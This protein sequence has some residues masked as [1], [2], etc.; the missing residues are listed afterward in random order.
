VFP[1]LGIYRPF[2]HQHFH[3]I[4]NFNPIQSNE[5]QNSNNGMMGGTK[6]LCETTIRSKSS[7]VMSV[8]DEDVTIELP[9]WTRRGSKRSG[10][11]DKEGSERFSSGQGSETIREVTSQT[12]GMSK[13]KI[14]TFQ[15]DEIVQFLLFT[16]SGKSSAGVV[17]RLVD[18]RFEVVGG[19]SGSG[20]SMNR[21]RRSIHRKL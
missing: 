19:W 10:G 11:D 20:R 3:N 15:A 18:L 4:K 12:L 14:I 7:S 8:N 21:I 1:P 13:I 6:K 9:D 5:N 17:G 16:K 2:I